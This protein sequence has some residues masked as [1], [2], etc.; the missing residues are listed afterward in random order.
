ME[1]RGSYVSQGCDWLICTSANVRADSSNKGVSGSSGFK[2]DPLYQLTLYVKV[3]KK[4]G[5][6]YVQ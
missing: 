1:K 2:G 6:N 5:I 4:L 3:R